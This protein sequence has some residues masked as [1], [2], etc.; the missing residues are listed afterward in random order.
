[1]NTRQYAY[2]MR[3]LKLSKSVTILQSFWNTSWND[4]LQLNILSVIE[5]HLKVKLIVKIVTKRTKILFQLI[6]YR[7]ELSNSR[8]EKI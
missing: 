8:S 1:M 2:K 3:T 6:H 7:A 5:K 4:C